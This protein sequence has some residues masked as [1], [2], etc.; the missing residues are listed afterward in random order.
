MSMRP[1][2]FGPLRPPLSLTQNVHRDGV[3]TEEVP[4]RAQAS[5]PPV[6]RADIAPE[7]GR[8]A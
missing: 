2:T 5:D 1:G 8:T 7:P 3:H 4:M 6:R